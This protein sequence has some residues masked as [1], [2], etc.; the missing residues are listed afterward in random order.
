[1]K[2]KAV[3]SRTTTDM[4]KS[5]VRSECLSELTFDCYIDPVEFGRII[6]DYGD[7]EIQI[8]IESKASG[9]N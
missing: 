8:T 3:L 5:K 1:M 6:K 9:S 7:K 4:I 2:F